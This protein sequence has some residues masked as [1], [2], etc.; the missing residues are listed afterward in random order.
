MRM[1]WGIA[2]V[3]LLAQQSGAPTLISGAA[4]HEHLSRLNREHRFKAPLFGEVEITRLSPANASCVDLGNAT[5]LT[6]ENTREGGLFMIREHSVD[7]PSIAIASIE[8]SLRVGG[9]SVS[10]GEYVVFAGP[11]VLTFGTDPMS[12]SVDVTLEQPIPEARLGRKSSDPPRLE[13]VIENSRAFLVI[14]G[15]RLAITK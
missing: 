6:I 5:R 3:I 11:K 12:N 15:N 14:A 10:P 2:P 8:G 9:T 7:M 13:I 1:V 4:A